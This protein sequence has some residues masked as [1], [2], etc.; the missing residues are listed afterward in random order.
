[1]ISLIFETRQFRVQI[2]DN[3]AFVE[4]RDGKG[5]SFRNQYQ[6]PIPVDS[7]HGRGEIAVLAAAVRN[8]ERKRHGDRSLRDALAHGNGVEKGVSISAGALPSR[9]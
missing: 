3:M 5:W 4:S 1:M 6:L 7:L 2:R 8:Y 9:L